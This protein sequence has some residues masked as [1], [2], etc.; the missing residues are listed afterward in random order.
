M[1]SIL[2]IWKSSQGFLFLDYDYFRYD[3][4]WQDEVLYQTSNINFII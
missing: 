4:Y 2:L 1:A 3:Q